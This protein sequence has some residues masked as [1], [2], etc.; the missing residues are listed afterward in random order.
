MPPIVDALRALE[1]QRLRALVDVDAGLLD[2][3]H[4][5][6]FVLVNPSGGNWSKAEYVGGVVSG[7]IN[8]RRFEAVSGID[9][10]A[11]GDL[12]VLRY[13]SAIDIHVRGQEPG[14]LECWHMDCY[15]RADAG[16][17]WQVVWSQATQLA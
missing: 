5:P 16:S 1:K 13:R 10:L 14:P 6:D 11:D 9:V 7:R 17:P 8:Y 2:E 15:R 12:A 4:A 3:L